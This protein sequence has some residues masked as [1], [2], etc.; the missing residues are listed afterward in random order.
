MY[1]YRKSPQMHQD[2]HLL[3]DNFQKFDRFWI[4]H[5]NRQYTRTLKLTNFISLFVNIP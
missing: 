3:A 5:T 1:I 4:L 2:L